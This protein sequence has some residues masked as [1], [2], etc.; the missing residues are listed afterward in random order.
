MEMDIRFYP[1]PMVET[2]LEGQLQMGIPGP[3]GEKGD[4][5][6]DGKSAY[7]YALEG[8]YAGTEAEF[9]KKLA[10]DTPAPSGGSGIHIGGEAPTD[11]SVEVWIDKQAPTPTVN[12][13]NCDKYIASD[14]SVSVS[15]SDA[16]VGGVTYQYK[17]N[18]GSYT[19][20]SS[21]KLTAEANKT[22]NATV[23]F[24]VCDSLS[25]CVETGEYK[26]YT[27]ML[28]LLHQHHFHL[29]KH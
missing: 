24:K 26:I 4:A 13:P 23:K 27:D 29:L 18:S 10:E 2:E 11:E 3:K 21:Y 20:G 14:S 28:L 9:A 16:G 5:G 7:A 25:N 19:S 22:K 17:L 8:G 15:G 1:L 6:A 12:C